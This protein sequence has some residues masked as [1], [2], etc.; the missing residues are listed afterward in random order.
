MIKKLVKRSVILYL[1]VGTLSALINFI[2]FSFFYGLF[3]L[4]YK[5]SLTIGYFL[6]AAFNFLA[7]RHMTFRSHSHAAHIQLVK[8]V[9]V[10]VLNY[11]AN[12]SIAHFCVSVLHFSPYFAVIIAIGAMVAF[13]YL[14]S[15]YWVYSTSP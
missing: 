12:L 9:V 1:V 13:T 15:K 2:V 4:H 5:L 8:Y 7:N 3:H 10:L 14:L 11:L 6:S